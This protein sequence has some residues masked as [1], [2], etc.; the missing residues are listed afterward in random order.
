[1][2]VYGL[3]IGN[4]QRYIELAK[5]GLVAALEPGDPVIES[6]DNDSIF[7]AYNEILD[8]ALTL[9][10]LEALVLLH[11]DVVLA[12]RALAGRLRSFFSDPQI[13][14]V[15]VVGACGVTNLAWWE[16]DGRGRCA[17]TRGLV[18]FG[19]G[20]HLVDAVDGL[21]LALSP[22]AVQ[23][24]RFDAQTFSGFHGYDIDLCF[25]ARSHGR[26]VV[27]TDI[28]LFHAT[29]GGYGDRTSFDKANEEFQRKWPR[30][31]AGALPSTAP[32]RVR[33]PACDR[34]GKRTPT[35]LARR[36]PALVT[37]AIPTYNR[38]EFIEETLGS[39]LAQTWPNL[40]ILVID[41]A[42]VDRTLEI[43]EKVLHR[44]PAV[45]IHRAK[46]NRGPFVNFRRCL[47]FANGQFV[48]LLM[49]DDLLVPDAVERLALALTERPDVTLATS[50][51]QVIDQ[52][53]FP[54]PPI[55]ATVPLVQQDAF[56]AGWDVGD[57]V[58]RT[59]QNR[60]GEPSTVLF[61]RSTAT[62]GEMFMLGSRYFRYNGDLALWLLLLSRGNAFYCADQLSSF[63]MHPQQDQGGAH[64]A[65]AGLQEWFD[66]LDGGES[67]GFL[68]D[69]AH[70]RQAWTGLLTLYT[71]AYRE[72]GE[73]PESAWL[74]NTMHRITRKLVAS[75]GSEPPMH[76]IPATSV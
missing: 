54:Q 55:A 3:C 69:P 19:G 66:L 34:S 30:A 20:T 75:A 17:E 7:T 63:R 39:V 52:S 26:S 27:V 45:T 71:Q 49:S 50:A 23:T 21:L 56:L 65:L 36:K 47:Q 35:L 64:A 40:E 59:L 22:W 72:Q 28:A 9:P 61:R 32:P 42:S 10:A 4:E 48:K 18:D 8:A 44:H 70:R 1:M 6:R 68:R 14:V 2:I 15:G 12:D 51:R 29:K 60:I 25:Q 24:L 11:E 76:S 73:Q 13:A 57:A 5:P 31:D 46:R 74:P 33:P 53:G 37:V 58:L 62:V 41:N 43:V 16:A 38:E 67:L